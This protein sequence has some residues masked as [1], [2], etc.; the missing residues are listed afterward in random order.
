MAAS[1]GA[2]LLGFVFA[3]SPRET[4]GATV[5]AIAASLDALPVR[6]LLVGIIVDASGARAKAA[7]ELALDGV[8][9]AVQYHG[10]DAFG[11]FS[12]I[13][14]A[15]GSY[16]IGRYAVV[17]LGSDDDLAKIDALA[18]NGEPRVLVDAR[19]AGIAGGTGAT[20]PKSLVRKLADR[21]VLW[22]AGGINPTNVRGYIDEFAPELI[23][24]SSGLESAPGK[25]DHVALKAFFREIDR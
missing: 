10:E 3:E 18:A 15:G 14:E 9:D 2:D 24:A 7:Y 25:K 4:D 13:D 21:G 5:R 17:R 6:P 11:D 8:L 12:R 19:V 16:G 23:D 22:L 20:I 1:L